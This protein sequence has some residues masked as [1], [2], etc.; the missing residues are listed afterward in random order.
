MRNALYLLPLALF[1]V[2]TG[3]GEDPFS[4]IVEIDLPDHEAK[5]TLVLHVIGGDTFVAPYID[6]SR[7][8]DELTPTGQPDASF[9]LTQSGEALAQVTAPVRTPLELTPRAGAIPTARL[10]Y[11]ARVGV[12]GY[13]DVVATQTMPTEPAITDILF[14]AEGTVGIE[15]FRQDRWEVDITDPAGEANYYL[16]RSLS[17]SGT[18]CFNSNQDQ[19]S[20][21]IDRINEDYSNFA[22][23]PDPLMRDAYD[24]G[25]LISD[26]TFDGEN[27]TLR[28]NAEA[29]SRF[30]VLDVYSL[31]EDG[32]RYFQSKAGYDRSQD[33]PFAEPANVY[34]NIEGG[35]GIFL[36]SNRRRIVRRRRE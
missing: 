13:D 5:P 27:Y 7:P 4:Q 18:T 33:N 26:E 17:V 10:T 31:T 25:F 32:F 9:L 23:S 16:L 24:F 22:E 21:V 14:E 11:T 1:I 8:I 2:L 15:G 29:Y 12:D 19:D 30:H 34:E 28:L 20:C 6:I 36:V 35:H 3:C